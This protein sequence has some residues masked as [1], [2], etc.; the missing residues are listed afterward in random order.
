MT[1]PR[2]PA[3][4]LPR[5]FLAILVAGAVVLVLLLVRVRN[6]WTTTATG[7]GGAIITPAARDASTALVDGAGAPLLA[8]GDAPD[9]ADVLVCSHKGRGAGPDFPAGA[10]TLEGI[11]ALLDAGVRC[12]DLDVRV[13]FYRNKSRS[14]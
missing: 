14:V 5:A 2:P 12:F 6:R 9:A 7:G 13:R 8:A 10:T 1:V 3:P 4:R 11:E